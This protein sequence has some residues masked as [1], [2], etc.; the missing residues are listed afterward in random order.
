MSL[1]HSKISAHGRISIPAKIRRR[2]GVQ[3]GDSLEWDE[4]DGRIVVRRA[5]SASS[6]ET[7]PGVSNEGI[8]KEPRSE[9]ERL[10]GAK[11][12]AR[13]HDLDALAGT[14]SDEEAAAFDQLLAEQR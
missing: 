6:A 13:F 14:W 4:E 3:P 11:T 9:H 1:A 2:L 10:D 5:A 8:R 12:L 7:S